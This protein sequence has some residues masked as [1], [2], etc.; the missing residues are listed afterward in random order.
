[1]RSRWAGR[2][3][4]GRRRSRALAIDSGGTVV[5][6]YEKLHLPEEPGFWET[7]HYEPGTEP[8]RRID[9]FGVPIGVQLCS[10]NNRPEGAHLIGAQ[11]GMAM[12]NPRATEEK[13]YQRWKTVFRA[14]A[15]TS[16]LYILSVNRPHPEDGV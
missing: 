12:I 8:P 7:R 15:L 5:A 6:R 14:N 16:T 3:R 13:T 2:A 10:D 4:E 11:G 1:M 9:A